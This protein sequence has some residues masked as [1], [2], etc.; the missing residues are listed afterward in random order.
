MFSFV[1][2]LMQPAP[3]ARQPN[4][5]DCAINLLS[6]SEHN[7]QTRPEIHVVRNEY[8]VEKQLAGKLA[9]GG[10]GT[11]HHV[12]GRDGVLVKIYHPEILADQQRAARL[13]RK[14]SDMA[15][16]QSL[17][18]HGRI[19]WPLLPL[20]SAGDGRW[21]GYAMQ[22]RAGKSLREI[23]GNP[24]NLARTAPSWHRQHLVRLCADFL[25][26]I[27]LLGEQRALPVDFNPSNFLVDLTDARMNFIDCDGYQFMGD[28]GMH[29]CEA[30]LPE[31][32]APEVISRTGWS[33]AA[34]QPGS[35]RFSIGMTLFYIL[36]LGNSPYRHRNGV[37]PVQ[38]L[39]NGSCALGKGADCE[40]P[41]G[42]SYLIWSHLTFK[43]KELFIRCFRN[44]HANPSVRPSISEWR[45]ALL[46]YNHCLL[47]GHADASLLPERPKSSGFRGN[48]EC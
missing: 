10:E 2:N 22:A 32:A 42:S 3:P 14:I 23:C 24:L 46:H 38:N 39:I 11:I 18:S 16:S 8:G 34:V 28:H 7:A 19:A 30:I 44:G 35:L 31:M 29:L 12:A 26:T 47:K 15:A 13:Q 37:D 20:Y 4:L 25:D 9:H 21:C 48:P 43:L 40:L 17:R 45:D 27:E 5:F 33:Q 41:R 36:N 6:P 1:K